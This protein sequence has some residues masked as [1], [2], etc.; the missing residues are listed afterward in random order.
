MT[1]TALQLKFSVEMDHKYVYKLCA[2]EMRGEIFGSQIGECE[3]LPSSGVLRHAVRCGGNWP[4]LQKWSASV[5]R[6]TS[7]GGSRNL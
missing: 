7:D 6:A 2:H 5:T 3:D 4:V 1:D